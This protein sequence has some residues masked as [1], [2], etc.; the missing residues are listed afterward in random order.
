MKAE[1]EILPPKFVPYEVICFPL[2]CIINSSINFGNI[3]W[4]TQGVDFFG[5]SRKYDISSHNPEFIPYQE[6]FM[7]TS[8]SLLGVSQSFSWKLIF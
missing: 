8:E 6:K 3:L 1:Q 2:I 5:V 7:Q 4:K